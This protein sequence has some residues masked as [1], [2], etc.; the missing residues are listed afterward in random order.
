[1]LVKKGLD[2]SSADPFEINLRYLRKV[3]GDANWIVEAGTFDGTTARELSFLF[4]EAV[5]FSFEPDRKL[6]IEALL[7]NIGFK[8]IYLQNCGLGVGFGYEKFNESQG[9][10][11]GVGSFRKPTGIQMHNPEVKFI[12]ANSY[13]LIICSVD[14]FLTSAQVPF[15]DLIWLDVQGSELDVFMGANKYLNLTRFIYLE[16]STKEMYEGATL[17]DEIVGYLKNYG[18]EVMNE[19]FLP[20]SPEGNILLHNPRFHQP[21]ERIG[22]M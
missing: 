17:K 14:E 1:M 4:P 22:Q 5:V 12:G 13:P 15:L 7:R 16:V 6:F 9:K 2:K 21:A 3:M 11:R 20:S 19:Y 8:N 10:H 18:F